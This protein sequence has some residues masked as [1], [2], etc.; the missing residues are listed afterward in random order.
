[1]RN[2]VSPGGDTPSPVT[3]QTAK[4]RAEFHRTDPASARL[5]L[6]YEADS[7][8]APISDASDEA[9]QTAVKNACQQEI[10]R[11]RV[12]LHELGD[13]V[14]DQ[15]SDEGVDPRIEHTT[16]YDESRTWTARQTD[17]V[18]DPSAYHSDTKLDGYK[19]ASDARLV[20]QTVAI[21]VAH[22]EQHIH[23]LYRDILADAT[24]A[25]ANRRQ[26][27]PAETPPPPSSTTA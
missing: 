15:L 19:G 7:V 22:R 8:E 11:M 12:A 14:A 17:F 5:V 24:A 1:M 26:S 6:D 3:V 4:G 16:N 13:A 20:R 18:V 9:L 10:E 21:T 2:A 23:K 27:A 25:R